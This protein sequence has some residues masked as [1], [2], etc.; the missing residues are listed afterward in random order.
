MAVFLEICLVN[1]NYGFGSRCIR[2]GL[3][4]GGIADF[5]PVPA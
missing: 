5:Q 1:D 3:G 4:F 2:D